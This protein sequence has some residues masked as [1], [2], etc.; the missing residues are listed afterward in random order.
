[1]VARLLA[2]DDEARDA[3]QVASWEGSRHGRR[4]FHDEV[5]AFASRLPRGTAGVKTDYAD[6]LR[7]SVMPPEEVRSE[8]RGLWAQM[9]LGI[10]LAVVVGGIYATYIPRNSWLEV[11]WGI[12]LVMSGYVLFLTIGYIVDCGSRRERLVVSAWLTLVAAAVVVPFIPVIHQ[13]LKVRELAYRLST[14]SKLNQ[15]GLAMLEYNTNHGSFPGQ[16][17]YHNGKPVLSWRVALLPYL[18]ENDLYQQFRLDE[19]WDSPH[20]QA[21]LKL[22]PR[23]YAAADGEGVKTYT[24]FFQVFV[25]RPGASPRD[26]AMFEARPGPGRRLSEVRDRDTILIVEAREAVPWIK[27]EDI[28][29]GDPDAS[30]G[31]GRRLSDLI[32]RRSLAYYHAFFC[33]STAHAVYRE[34][35]LGR[36]PEETVRAMIT[37]CGGEAVV[38]AF[39]EEGEHNRPVNFR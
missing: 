34:D 25:S 20:N 8:V 5:K 39:V 15:I 1:M 21:L 31:S 10:A 23:V 7:P 12:P 18:E 19:P 30:G 24:T 14:R 38:P 6:K 11:L 9:A 16:A 29:F 27:P 36:D 32:G 22:M 33:D 35:L 3:L 37:P 2:L 17:I 26:Q 13:V 4:A 28:P